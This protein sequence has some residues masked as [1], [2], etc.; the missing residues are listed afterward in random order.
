MITMYNGELVIKPTKFP[1]GTQ[2]MFDVQIR[3][4]VQDITWRYHDDEE[5]VRLYYLVNHIRDVFKERGVKRSPK[6]TL[7]MPYVPNAR[8]DRVHND[9]EVFTLKHFAKMIN[10]MKFSKVTVFDPHS[11][12]TVKMIKNVEVISADKTI[13]S[14]INGVNFVDKIGCVYFPD[15]GAM[16]RYV[17]EVKGAEVI[18]YGENNIP[19]TYGQKERDFETGKILG[20]NVW[21]QVDYIKGNNILII[22][23]IVS[24]GGTMYYS[25]KKLKELGAKDIYIYCSHLEDSA[26][27]ENDGKIGKLLTAGV[28]RKVYTTNSIDREVVNSSIVEVN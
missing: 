7:T 3:D 19:I 27:D 28:V 12:A 13:N 9:K 4:G 23:D 10:S 1:D 8:M 26:F 15:S 2:L 20:L 5:L 16:S 24:F 22:D 6:I 25:T 17:E 21:G 11:D 18:A 14:V